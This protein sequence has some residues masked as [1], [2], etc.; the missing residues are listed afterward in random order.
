LSKEGE[1]FIGGI[2]HH[3]DSIVPFLAPSPNGCERVSPDSFVG[4]YKIWGI[5]NK[6]APIRVC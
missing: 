5:E 6:E 4:G 3:F 2:L 1:N